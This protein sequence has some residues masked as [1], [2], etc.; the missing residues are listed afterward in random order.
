MKYSWKLLFVYSLLLFVV[1]IFVGRVTHK[2]TTAATITP[3]DTT[4]PRS[5]DTVFVPE[6]LYA[7]QD[8]IVLEWNTPIGSIPAR[9]IES[10]DSLAVDIE[11]QRVFIPF[12]L[13]R[14]LRGQDYGYDLITHPTPYKITLPTKKPLIDPFAEANIWVNQ[15][16]RI[17]GSATGGLI[18]KQHYLVSGRVEVQD[19]QKAYF[20]AGIG[21]RF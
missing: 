10:N 12:T 6:T 8:T 3:A 13:R 4:M 1:G 11:K 20:L 16:W 9:I 14:K 2:T 7:K 17:S 18:I 21:Y 15:S 5:K 19:D